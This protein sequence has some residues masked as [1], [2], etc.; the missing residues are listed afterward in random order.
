VRLR[1]KQVGIKQSKLKII[2][3]PSGAIKRL[4][5]LEEELND[6]KISIPSGAIKSR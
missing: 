6:C 1:V 5:E 2:S 4:S 3:I